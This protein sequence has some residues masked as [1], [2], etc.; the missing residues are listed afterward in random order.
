[1]LL[2]YW[3]AMWMYDTAGHVNVSFVLVEDSRPLPSGAPRRT[4]RAK[5]REETSS[6]LQVRYDMQLLLACAAKQ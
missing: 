1:M 4:T 3:R 2:S 5:I 6:H